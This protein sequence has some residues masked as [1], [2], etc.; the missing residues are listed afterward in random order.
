MVRVCLL[1][2]Q[3]CFMIVPQEHVKLV[4]LIVLLVQVHQL[5]AQNVVLAFIFTYTMEYACQTALLVMFLTLN[6]IHV[7]LVQ[8]TV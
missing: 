4:I 3:D 1:V 6:Q 5:P 2:L 8:I 7:M